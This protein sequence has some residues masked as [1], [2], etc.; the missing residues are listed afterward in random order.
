[1]GWMGFDASEIKE[2]RKRVSYTLLVGLC[3]VIVLGWARGL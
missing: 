1:M 3:C 2:E